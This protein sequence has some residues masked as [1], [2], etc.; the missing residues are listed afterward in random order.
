M[1]ESGRTAVA[2]VSTLFGLV[3]STI[4]VPKVVNNYLFGAEKYQI[5]K[6]TV[7]SG[8]NGIYGHAHALT[9]AKRK[10]KLTLEYHGK[11]RKVDIVLPENATY[12]I[13]E[14]EYGHNH[15]NTALETIYLINHADN[16][17]YLLTDLTKKVTSLSSGFGHT[18]SLTVTF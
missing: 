11:T 10:D 8:N 13:C 16:Q 6:Y 15:E 14:K 17:I 1:S 2:V 9:E 12:F 7:S 5:G 3:M 18:H 4:L